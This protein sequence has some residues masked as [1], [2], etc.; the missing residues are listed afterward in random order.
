MPKT[1]FRN[2]RQMSEEAAQKCPRNILSS[3]RPTEPTTVRA[4]PAVNLEVVR[5]RAKSLVA[6]AKSAA[7]QRRCPCY[8]PFVPISLQCG[9]AWNVSRTRARSDTCSH[10][11]NLYRD[12]HVLAALL[13]TQNNQCA[14]VHTVQD[15]RVNSSFVLHLHDLVCLPLSPLV[16][17]QSIPINGHTLLGMAPLPAHVQHPPIVASR[18]QRAAIVQHPRTLP[19]ISLAILVATS[20]A[21]R[22]NLK[23]HTKSFNEDT[24]RKR[25]VR[26]TQITEWTEAAPSPHTTRTKLK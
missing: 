20:H 14:A 24:C 17:L 22:T 7:S 11:S 2:A 19:N 10:F 5:V 8:S 3:P 26:V 25:F 12:L 15:A 6:A 13:E 4:H 16:H 1:L 21:R 18:C 23:V 9:S